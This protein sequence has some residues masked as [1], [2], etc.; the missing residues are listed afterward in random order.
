MVD[1]SADMDGGI[2]VEV[3][4]RMREEVDSNNIRRD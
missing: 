2:V 4:V 1:E 3:R